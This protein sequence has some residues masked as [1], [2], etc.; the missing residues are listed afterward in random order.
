MDGRVWEEASSSL[1]LLG[2]SLCDVRCD[3]DTDG[4]SFLAL[5]VGCWVLGAGERVA[6][7]GWDVLCTHRRT[8]AGGVGVSGP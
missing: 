6:R 3:A 5:D 1:S 8:L 2:L 4:P 7:V